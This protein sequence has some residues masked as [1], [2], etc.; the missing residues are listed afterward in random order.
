[1]TLAVTGPSICSRVFTTVQD[2]GVSE[3]STGVDRKSMRTYG[4]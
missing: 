3:A 4:W 1:V 2:D